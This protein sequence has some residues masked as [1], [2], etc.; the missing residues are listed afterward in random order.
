MKTLIKIALVALLVLPA[1]K[2]MAA[3]EALT[4]A[5][6][7]FASPDDTVDGLGP[8]ISTLVSANLSANPD[9][10]TVERAD[11]EKAL[12]EQELGLSGTIQADTAAKVG[13]LTGAKVL[14]TGR[15][16]KADEQTII[17][18]KIIGTETSRVYG[19][20]V[21][22]KPDATITDM[23]AEMA[24]KIAAD[25]VQ[26]GDTLTAKTVSLD[27]RIAKIKQALGGQKLPSVSVK[28]SE[29]HFRQT[30]VYVIDPAAQTELSKV[31]QQ[32][33]FQVVDDNSTNRP[34][35][36]ITGEALSEFGM[37]KGNLQSCK[38]RVEVKMRDRKSGEILAE[39]AQTSV[40]VDVAEH[41]AK[42]ALQNAADALAERLLPKL[43]N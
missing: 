40:A 43:G 37:S 15:V 4:V 18:A 27:D 12:G 9:I 32:C 6:L 39:D 14:V 23:A 31:L 42:T 35:I 3:G 2:M 34:D 16:F 21:T 26:R 25:V 5:V 36:E 13:Q 19:E 1:G 11:L 41:I 28:I 29:Q 20:I 30:I 33:G 38:A 8:K 17:V 24:T 22:G 7:D 10:V